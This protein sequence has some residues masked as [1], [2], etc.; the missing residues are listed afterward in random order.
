M[1]YI[2]IIFIIIIFLFLFLLKLFSFVASELYSYLETSNI[3]P[4]FWYI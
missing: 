3:F 2:F 4:Y 1:I